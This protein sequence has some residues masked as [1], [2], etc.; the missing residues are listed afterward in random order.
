VFAEHAT[1]PAIPDPVGDFMYLRLQKG[2]D[3]IATCYPPKD[4]DAWA[5]RAE[6]WAKGGAPKDL[7]Q[8]GDAKAA[9]AAPRDVFVY[10][11][12]EGKVRAPVGAMELIKR[13]SG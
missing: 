6:T 5:K 9:K 2:Q 4:L 10:F 12:H 1:Y 7:A 13:V 11:I 3:S 8:V